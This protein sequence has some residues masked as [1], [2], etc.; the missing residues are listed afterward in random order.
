MQG[1]LDDSDINDDSV[2]CSAMLAFVEVV[3]IETFAGEL[4]VRVVRP[5]LC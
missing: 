1:W 3:F 4:F 2:G 5:S